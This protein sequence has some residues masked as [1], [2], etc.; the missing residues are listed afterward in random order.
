MIIPSMR[1]ISNNNLLMCGKFGKKL[2]RGIK[3]VIIPHWFSSTMRRV[4]LLEDN[5]L[6]AK[7]ENTI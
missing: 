4:A 2:S 1:F 7:W 3:T 5:K 6:A